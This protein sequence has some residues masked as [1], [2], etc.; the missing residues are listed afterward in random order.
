MSEKLIYIDEPK[1]K[2]GFNQS[3]EDSRDGLTL[4]GPYDKGSG[5]V[6]AGF[7]GTQTSYEYYNQF[8][9]KMNTP[10]FTKSS[11]RPIFPRRK[12][13]FWYRLVS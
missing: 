6:R 12:S 4:F 5:I 1:L 10:I 11:G 13:S 8:V 3:T 2:F 7:V 9:K